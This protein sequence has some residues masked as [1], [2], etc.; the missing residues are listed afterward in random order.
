MRSLMLE[1]A[2]EQKVTKFFKKDYLKRFY[3]YSME[4]RVQ[5]RI[6]FLPT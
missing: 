4:C 2:A 6:P 5:E 3:S 1:F